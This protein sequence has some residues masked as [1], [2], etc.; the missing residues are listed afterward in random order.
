MD[1]VM[2]K[3]INKTKCLEELLTQ[4]KYLIHVNHC[5]YYYYFLGE[6]S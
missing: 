1:V 5:Y 2:N 3:W 4:Y 6:M